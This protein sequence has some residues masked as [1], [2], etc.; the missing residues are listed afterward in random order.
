V[1]TGERVMRIAAEGD[2]EVEA[3][4]PVGDAIPLPQDAALRLYLNA[5]PLDA[6]DATV[7]Y[8]AHDA[9]QRPDGTYAYRI[10]AVLRDPSSQRVGLKGTAKVSGGWVPVVYWVLRRPLAVLRQTLGW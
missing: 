4:L 6:L 7:R 1:V 8:M 2:T 3:W 9:Q 10:R 5:S